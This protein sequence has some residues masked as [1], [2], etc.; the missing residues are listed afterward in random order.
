MNN[1]AERVGGAI[2]NNGASSIKTI[3]GSFTNN[4]VVGRAAEGGALSIYGGGAI[5]N[6]EASFIKNKA[7]G[8]EKF[9]KGG[10]IE[11]WNNES[12]INS[13]KGDFIENSAIAVTG[14][15]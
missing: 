4:S 13:I 6:L 9:A 7:E 3:S 14:T 5:E 8:N 12:T 15:E 10:A 1:T 11:V 2:F